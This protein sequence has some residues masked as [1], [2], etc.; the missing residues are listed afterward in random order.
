M[1]PHNPRKRVGQH[2]LHDPNVIRRIVQVIQP[3]P[4]E[5]LVEIG[6][7]QGA[8]TRP[9]LAAAGRLQVVELDRDLVAALRAEYGQDGPLTVHAGDALRFDFAALA[10]DN[11]RLRVVGN[12][13]YNI[14]T[15]LIFHLLSQA[16]QIKDMVFMLQ[17]EV[18]DRLA[19]APD[20]KDYGRLSVMV[21][22][23]CE[24][25]ALFEVGPGAFQPPPKVYSA[26]VALRPRT[27]PL[28][29]S[30][31]AVHARLVAQAF[32]QRRKTLRNTLKGL[33]DEADICAAGV[34][35]S[36]RAETLSLQTFAALAAQLQ[37]RMP[38]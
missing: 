34:D 26:V 1:N 4:G 9:L 27:R 32:A 11:E 5:T 10:G 38:L 16:A 22:T 36:V 2:F 6:P 19:A 31:P 23:Y 8:L 17:K 20:S 29:D 14:S 24:V 35:P 33:L 25:D 13:P 3:Q 28:L 30:S 12:L 18:V 15:P 21:Q 37:Q 7:G